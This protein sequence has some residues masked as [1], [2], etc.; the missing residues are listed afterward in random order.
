MGFFT[1]NYFFNRI[2]YSKF[3]SFWAPFWCR[4]NKEQNILQLKKMK[5]IFFLSYVHFRLILGIF[6]GWN[7]FSFSPGTWATISIIKTRWNSRKSFVTITQHTLFSLPINQ[8]MG[9]K[10]NQE[11]ERRSKKA[12]VSNLSQNN[13]CTVS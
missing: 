3:P 10:T 7:F 6:V 2:Y 4:I 12:D 1:W 13:C 9:E 8:W 11:T 5:W